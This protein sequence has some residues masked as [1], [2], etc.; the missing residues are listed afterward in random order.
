MKAPNKIDTLIEH[1]NAKWNNLPKI[2]FSEASPEEIKRIVIAMKAKNYGKIELLIEYNPAQP[3]YGIYY[4]CKLLHVS[5][6]TEQYD[7]LKTT[8]WKYYHRE[9]LEDDSK[10]TMEN[11]FLPDCEICCQKDENKVWL[12]WIRLD[13]HLTMREALC[14]LLVLYDAFQLQGFTVCETN[15]Q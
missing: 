10:I 6:V 11:V 5:E 4:G 3:Q 13:E 15:L 12:F 14:H 2:T 7:S 8:I 9:V 1:Y